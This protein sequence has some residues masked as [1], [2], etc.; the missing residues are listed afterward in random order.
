MI[1]KFNDFITE[2]LE[3]VLF[4]HGGNIGGQ[5]HKPIKDKN[6]NP[7]PTGIDRN[8]SNTVGRE[9]RTNRL[10]SIMGSTLPNYR[11]R[12]YVEFII[13]ESKRIS[14]SNSENDKKNRLLNIK[15]IL[16]NTLPDIAKHFDVDANSDDSVY[17]FV[18]NKMDLFERSYKMFREEYVKNLD[19]RYNESKK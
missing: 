8:V 15:S 10:L 2:K 19:S 9:K 5:H 7:I 1:T 16:T 11:D 4:P 18:I 17:D 3:G 14:K 13:D 12:E 6:F